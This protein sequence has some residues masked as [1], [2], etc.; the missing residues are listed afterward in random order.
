MPLSAVLLTRDAEAVQ[1]LG[2][3][4]AELRIRLD[5]HASADDAFASLVNQKFDAIF[6]DCDDIA[7]GAET[8][9]YIRKV[10]SSRR[11]ILFA[12]VHGTTSTQRAFELG[13]NFVLEKPVTPER[14][15]R[16]IR[17]ALGLMTHERRRYFRQRLDTTVVVWAGTQMKEIK[18]QLTNLSEGGMAIRLKAGTSVPIDWSLRF[19]FRLPDTTEF[20][21][22]KGEVAWTDGRGNAGIKFVHLPMAQ[23]ADLD[24]WLVSHYRADRELLPTLMADTSERQI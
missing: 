18:G 9:S 3:M 20:I 16:S 21:D 24:R 10:P 6:I 8:L 19:Q 11:S 5:C 23:R 17:A 13:A 14:V 4:A 22:G 7:D 1:V 2:R 12:I 15:E